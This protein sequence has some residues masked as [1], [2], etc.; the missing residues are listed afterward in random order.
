MW[1][2]DLW[3]KPGQAP[4]LERPHR[5]AP[6]PGGFTLLS[7]V[8]LFGQNQELAENAHAQLSQECEQL[9]NKYM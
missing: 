6:R 9:A 5:G 1:E 8:W 7:E 3:K 4:E 2:V